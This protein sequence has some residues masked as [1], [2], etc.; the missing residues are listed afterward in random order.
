M[1]QKPDFFKECKEAL[2]KKNSPFK[3]SDQGFSPQSIGIEEVTF[4]K[5]LKY[6]EKHFPATLMVEV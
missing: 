4:Q 5:K 6:D 1:K 3:E 2:V